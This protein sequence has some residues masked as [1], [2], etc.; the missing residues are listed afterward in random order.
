ME[1]VSFSIALIAGIVSFLSP[2]VL[3]LLPSYLSFITGMSV[4]ELTQRAKD[5]ATRR[6]ILIHSSMFILGFTL[7][8]ILLGISASVA[9]RILLRYQLWISRIGGAFVILLGLQFTG[10]ISLPFLQRERRVRLKRKP[11]GYLGSFLVGIAF[12]AGWTPCVGP[13]LASILFYASSTGSISS[14]IGL[15]AVYSAGFAFPFFLASWGLDSFLRRYQKLR[16][17]LRVVSIISGLFLI[18]MGILLITNYF[19]TLTAL[20][21]RW[22]P[23]LSRFNI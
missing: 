17:H 13:I 11:V 7:V 19:L 20:F 2:C 12:A 5:P 3:P 15:L 21:N 8:F 10:L 23:F 4:D 14:G 16:R 18:G 1:R 6:L 22:F 9:G